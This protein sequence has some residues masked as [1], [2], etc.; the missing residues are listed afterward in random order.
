MEWAPKNGWL[1]YHQPLPAAE[2]A[3]AAARAAGKDRECPNEFIAAETKVN[4]AYRTYYA[5]HTAEAIALA[6]EALKKASE[7]CPPRPVAAPPPAPPAPA[8]V[9][10][11]PPPAPEVTISANPASIQ[12]GQCTNLAWSSSNVTTATI[13]QGVGAVDPKGTKQVCPTAT[14]QFTVAGTG[15]GGSRTASTTVTVTPPPVPAPRVVDRLTLHVNFDFDKS[16]IRKADEPELQKA[17]DF[18]KKYPGHKVLLEGHTDGLGGEAYNQRLSERRA[19]AVKNYLVKRGAVEAQ[20]IQTKGYGKSKPI[21]DNKTKQGRFQN[22][23][24]EVLIL[25]E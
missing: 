15:P 3:I 23:R 20:T 14:T 7:L 17:I 24:V 10:P 16:L 6:T 19:V 8:P 22:R 1:L 4:E 5:C 18:V 2:R 9:P 21:A 13:D 11:P 25:S 12:Q